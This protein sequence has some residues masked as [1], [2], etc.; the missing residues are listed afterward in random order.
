MSIPVLVRSVGPEPSTGYYTQWTT[1]VPIF[2]DLHKNGLDI[3]DD[4]IINPF[5]DV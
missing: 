1:F 2:P 3:T 5:F 4:Q